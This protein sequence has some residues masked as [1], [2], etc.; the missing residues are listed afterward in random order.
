MEVSKEV[1]SW[2]RDRRRHG[3]PGPAQAEARGQGD[4]AD[5]ASKAGLRVVVDLDATGC[6][7][8]PSGSS[9]RIVAPRYT[10]EAAITPPPQRSSHVRS[11]CL[12]AQRLRKA[13]MGCSTPIRVTFMPKLAA[14]PAPAAVPSARRM[15]EPLMLSR[16]LRTSG[17]RPPPVGHH[18]HVQAWVAFG[19]PLHCDPHNLVQLSCACGIIGVQA[20][21]R[22]TQKCRRRLR[23]QSAHSVQLMNALPGRRLCSSSPLRLGHRALPAAGRGGA[24]RPARLSFGRRGGSVRRRSWPVVGTA[25]ARCGRVQ[26]PVCQVG[27]SSASSPPAGAACWGR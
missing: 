13:H 12:A 26:R 18:L 21:H 8:D 14:R 1:R 4:V 10:H 19:H 24:D 11:T 22:G 5:L 27:R 20:R 3:C 15:P 16:A 25:A 9:N 2:L 6:G 23:V 7:L 17:C